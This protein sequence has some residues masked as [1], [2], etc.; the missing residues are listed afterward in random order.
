MLNVSVGELVV[1]GENEKE[2]VDELDGDALPEAWDKLFSLDSE[3]VVEREHDMVS[4]S[5]AVKVSDRT[6]VSVTEPESEMVFVSDHSLVVVTVCVSV[7]VCDKFNVRDGVSDNVGLGVGEGVVD[8]LGD[9]DKDSSRL[10]LVDD[11]PSEELVGVSD[12]V[13]V[14]EV[15]HVGDAEGSSECVP[16]VGLSDRVGDSLSDDEGDA[17][18]ESESV[19]VT[20]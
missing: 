3:V 4:S 1:S 7:T 8:S 5:V 16:N 12:S 10:V 19:A 9:K 20:D 13:S 15:E 17:E 2:G 11:V 6:S 14:G 18:Y